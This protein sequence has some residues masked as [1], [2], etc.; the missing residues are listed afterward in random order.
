LK[1][2][3]Y[4]NRKTADSIREQKLPT[5]KDSSLD[6]SYKIDDLPRNILSIEIRKVNG[7]LI[8]G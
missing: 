5:D 3:L 7:G 2:K 6:G 1:R 8:R 4:R